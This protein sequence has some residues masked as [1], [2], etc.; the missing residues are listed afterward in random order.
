MCVYP[1]CRENP[2][3]CMN[4]AP[5]SPEEFSAVAEAAA[6]RTEAV[7]CA[8]LDE[9]LQGTGLHARDLCRKIF[10]NCTVTINFHPDRIAGNGRLILDNLLADGEYK[11]QYETGTTNGGRTACP[12]GDRDLWEKQLFNEFYH[13][14]IN[15]PAARPRYGALNIMNYCDGASPRFGSCFFTLKPA[16]L[17][18]VTFAAG[19]SCTNPERL[20][21]RGCFCGI[22][23]A[24]FHEIN[25]TGRLLNQPG[26]TIKEAAAFLMNLSPHLTTTPGGALDEYIE[27]HIHG[28]IILETDVAALYLDDSFRAT[29]LECKARELCRRFRIELHFIPERHVKIEEID[30]LFRG[31]AMR[32]LAEKIDS[33]FGRNSGVLNARLIGLASCDSVQN[34]AAWS[35]SGSEP[36]LFQYFKQLWHTVVHHAR[37][38][39]LLRS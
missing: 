30:D 10:E 16:V 1:A 2:E 36:E 24:L 25:R 8:F 17:D 35:N 7:D 37:Q 27:A 33:A 39:S 20:G 4:Q 18:R 29:E 38:R 19:D 26:F 6:R 12:G 9:L 15:L 21:T 11:N 34:P 31:P 32:P 3:V 28:R 14:Q 13:T 23:K 5:V 22:L